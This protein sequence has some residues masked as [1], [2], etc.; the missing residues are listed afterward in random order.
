[1]E[2]VIAYASKTLSKSEQN[3]CT[4]YREL[5]VVNVFVR[6]FKHFLYGH[7]FL[8]RTDHASLIWLRNFKIEGMLARWISTLRNI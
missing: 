7:K 2:K 1:M 3:Y 8:I 5:L 6:H 4:T